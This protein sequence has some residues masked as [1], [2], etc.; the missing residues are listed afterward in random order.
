MKT[1]AYR[2]RVTY[3]GLTVEVKERLE[4]YSLIR[5]RG[6]DLIVETADLIFMGGEL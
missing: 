1:K 2:M 5:F 4:Q 6:R 3:F